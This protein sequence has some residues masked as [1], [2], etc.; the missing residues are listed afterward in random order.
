MIPVLLLQENTHELISTNGRLVSQIVGM[1]D[2]QCA[3]L[4][5]LHC[6]SA[7]PNDMLRVVHPALSAGFAGH[8]DATIRQALSQLVAAPPCNM[9][10]DVVSLPFSRGGLGLR[11]AVLTAN[12]AYWASWADSLHMIQKRH[13]AVAVRF[14][15]RCL[16]HMLQDPTLPHGKS[17]FALD[18]LHLP[19]HGSRLACQAMGSKQQQMAAG[20]NRSSA[21]SPREPGPTTFERDGPGIVAFSRRSTVGWPFFLFSWQCGGTVRLCT[22]PGLAPPSSLA[23]SPIFSQLLVCPS[24]LASTMQ[25]V[26]RLGCWVVGVLRWSQPLPEFAGRQGGH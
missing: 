13:P 15:K 9:C 19:G 24:P 17:W 20:S 21:L 8:H 11:N 26:R 4:L 5:L 14:C 22:V 1:S 3:W 18:S 25:L 7:R 23:S 10:W 2:L 6:A 12:A 16:S